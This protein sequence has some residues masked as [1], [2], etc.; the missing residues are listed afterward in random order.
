M[1]GD[2]KRLRLKKETVRRLDDSQLRQAL[3]G[4]IVIQAFT[5]RLSKAHPSYPTNL[6][7]TPSDG[8]GRWPNSQG[9]L[10]V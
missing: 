5:T 10:R 2:N 8:A 6:G 4:T 7:I 3:G 9:D 1:K